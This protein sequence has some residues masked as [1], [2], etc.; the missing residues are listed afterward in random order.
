MTRELRP[1]VVT[2]A[3]RGLGA[4]LARHFAGLGHDVAMCAGTSNGL[5]L[6][7]SELRDELGV[8]VLAVAVDVTDNA[9]VRAFAAQVADELG[10]SCA[11]VNNAGILGPVGPLDRV[12]LAAWRHTLDVNVVGT[13]TVTAAFVPQLVA[14]GGGAVVNLS[15]AGIGGSGTHGNI[16]AYTTSKGAVVA[17]TEALATELEGR[18][19]R[20]NAMAPGV[21]TTGFMDAVLE[22]APGV[23]GESLR[24]NA[25]AVRPSGGRAS[26]ELDANLAELM[27]FLVS[28]ESAWLTGKLVSARWDTVASLNSSRERLTRTSLLNLRRIDDTLF[29]EA[30]NQ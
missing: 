30:E 18:R 8:A 4:A 10:P 13:V 27:T 6:L 7:A 9:G 5:E 1:V 14:A 20:V 28:N 15:G 22:A 29:A 24:A 25:F 3:S 17:L 26:I 23:V 19:V 2:G 11:V 16:S 12:D 21:L